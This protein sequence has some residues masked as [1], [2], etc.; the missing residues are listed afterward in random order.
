MKNYDLPRPYPECLQRHQKEFAIV[1]QETFRFL[2][3]PRLELCI[4]RSFDSLRVP[5]RGRLLSMKEILNLQMVPANFAFGNN[6]SDTEELL[7]ILVKRSPLYRNK[8]YVFIQDLQHHPLFRSDPPLG[9]KYA[10]TFEDGSLSCELAKI[11]EILP[12]GIDII[13]RLPRLG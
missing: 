9:I 10:F 3:I 4:V 1:G 12:I 6:M 11:P 8:G 5:S 2:D 7:N 13:M